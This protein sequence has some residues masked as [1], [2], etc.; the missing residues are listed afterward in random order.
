MRYELA[1]RVKRDPMLAVGCAFAAGIVAGVVVKKISAAGRFK[2]G[3]A[4]I[5]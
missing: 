1:H 4:G 2:S 5:R 3:E